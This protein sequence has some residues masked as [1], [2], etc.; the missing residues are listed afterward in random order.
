[1]LRPL[2]IVDT[3]GATAVERTDA[4]ADERIRDRRANIVTRREPGCARRCRR[5]GV[6]AQAPAGRVAD[7]SA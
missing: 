4:S 7:M 1:M 5:S 3:V 2:R 6:A